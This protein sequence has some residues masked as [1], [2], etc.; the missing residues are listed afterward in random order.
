MT[1]PLPREHWFLEV[2]ACPDCASPFL[3]SGGSL[4]CSSCGF[5]PIE[6]GDQIDLRPRSPRPWI[7]SLRRVFDPISSLS[8][9]VQ[10]APAPLYD[11]PEAQRD[12]RELFSAL[13]AADV[14]GGDLLDLGCGPRDQA[15]PSG[16][17]GFRYVGIDLFSAEADVRADAHALP[18]LDE[19]F[20]VV[21]SYAVLEH[22]HNPFVA[23]SEVHRV[24]KP[25]GVFVG[26]VS[27]GEPFHDSFFHHTPW[28]LAAV[29]KAAG[30]ELGRLWPSRD[31]LEALA[32]MGR[33][34]APIRWVLRSL[35]KTD[36]LLPFLAPRRWLSWSAEQKL[37][38]ACYRSGSLCFLLAKYPTTKEENNEPTAC[39]PG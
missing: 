22:L 20:D 6:I 39:S 38:N 23:L 15:A 36:S 21:L 12:S 32:T 31:T 24:L 14:R 7:A 5:G 16:H 18:F 10:P 11:G 8:T 19:T 27:Q 25:G 13:L 33:Y 3:R 17:C 34:P 30:F 37:W 28:G 35:S 2:L 26:T 29:A 9:S 4:A 1:R